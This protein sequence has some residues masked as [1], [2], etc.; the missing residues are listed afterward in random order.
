VKIARPRLIF[1]LLA[2][3]LGLAGCVSDDTGPVPVPSV[4]CTLR[5]ADP[6]ATLAYGSILELRLVDF[7][8]R[9]VPSVV[10]AERVESNPGQP[11]LV[12]RLLYNATAI[13]PA[14]DY[15]VE[16]RILFKGRPLWVQSEPLPVITKDH[17][18]VVEVTLQPSS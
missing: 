18:T 5:C 13:D 1:V 4:V 10:L 15:G 9:D 8:R 16:A 14:H 17:P 3:V 12:F 2:L 11:P 6:A 7:T